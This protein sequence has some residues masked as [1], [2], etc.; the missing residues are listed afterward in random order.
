[1]EMI[2]T[3]IAN[4]ARFAAATTLSSFRCEADGDVDWEDRKTCLA[5]R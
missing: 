5:T 2:A 1:M 3:R 4:P